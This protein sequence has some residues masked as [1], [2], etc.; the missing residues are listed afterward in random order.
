MT[1]PTTP[2]GAVFSSGSYDASTYDAWQAFDAS[3][4]SMWISREAQVPASIGYAWGDGPR[5][6]TAYAITYANGSILTRAPSAW[7]FEGLLGDAWITL[8]RR[9]DEAGWKGTERRVYTLASPGSYSQ[10]RLNITDD[11]DPA[12]GIVVISVGR[13]ELLGCPP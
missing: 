11:N 10:Y 8:D 9:D 5:T 3:N 13:I 1:G 12:V 2:S 6:V 4:T 7:T